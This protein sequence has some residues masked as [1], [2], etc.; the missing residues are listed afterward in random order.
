MKKT[1]YG[2]VFLGI[3]LPVS[4]IVIYQNQ[5]L[6]TII[7]VAAVAVLL[8]LLFYKLTISVTNEYVKFSMGIG[9]INGNYKLCDIKQCKSLSYIPFGWGIRLRPGAV[10]FNVSGNKAIEL[11]IKGKARKVWIGINT[12]EE[13]VGYI[14]ELKAKP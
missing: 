11:E 3:I 10:L 13:I 9:I 14:N 2:W 8:L 7:G 12:P 6:N 5:T 4:G 1:Q